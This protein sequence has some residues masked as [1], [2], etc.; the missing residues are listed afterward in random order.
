MNRDH[1]GVILSDREGDSFLVGANRAWIKADGKDTSETYS[2]VEFA[3]APQ[4]APRYLIDIR[5]GMRLFTSWKRRLR[6]SWVTGRCGH[7]QELSS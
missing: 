3:L 7:E 1:G 4:S 6:P 2:V 5:S